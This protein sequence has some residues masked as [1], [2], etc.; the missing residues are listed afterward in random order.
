VFLFAHELV[1]ASQAVKQ[2]RNLMRKT[3]LSASL[4]AV[5]A[6]AVVVGAQTPQP[7]Q[8]QS[9]QPNQSITVA[10]CVQKEA[11]VLKRAPM[12]AN[13]GMSDEFVLTRATLKP[14]ASA[15]KTSEPQTKPTTPPEPTGTSGS[16]GDVGKVYRVT[17]DKEKDLQTYAGQRVEIVGKFKHEEDARRELAVGT[18]GKPPATAGELT[19]ANTPE[20]TIESIRVVSATCGAGK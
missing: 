19:A 11:D 20:I 3:F 6:C 10:G 16:A 8:T 18:S 15:P 7:S 13:V 12:A 9:P 14:A 1:I 2:R 5:V 17:G 4:A